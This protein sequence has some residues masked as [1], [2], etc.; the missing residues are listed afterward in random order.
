MWLFKTF[1]T[2]KEMS[3]FSSK[4]WKK[5]MWAAIKY[6]VWSHYAQQERGR[7]LQKL[8]KLG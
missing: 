3:N 8:A 4:G 5:R 2:N 1:N 6:D 7:K